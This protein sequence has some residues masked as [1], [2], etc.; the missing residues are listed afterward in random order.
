MAFWRP[1][2]SLAGDGSNGASSSE[3]PS[4]HF[5]PLHR[6]PLHAQ[7]AQL[8]VSARRTEILWAVERHAATV[9]V[10]ATGSGKSTQVPQY[11]LEAGWAADGKMVA[12]AQ[13]RRVAAVTL[14]ARVAQERGVA[15]GTEVGYAVRFDE[16]SDARATRLKFLTDGV[17]LREAMRDP[18]LSRYSVVML[19][20]QYPVDIEYLQEP[21]SADG[22]ILVFL[23]GQEE[24]DV[25][26]RA[27]SDRGGARLLPLP[28]YAALPAQLQES[29]FLPTPRHPV[30]RKLAFYNPFT[31]VE[32]LVTAPVSR[33]SAKQRAGR[34]GRV[35]PGKCFRLCTQTHF[36]TQLAKETL[37][38]IQRTSLAT[39][40]LYLLSMGVRDIAHFEFVSPPPPEA[41]MR[42]LEL[43]H[44]LGAV[45]GACRLVEPLGTH[46]AEFP[47]TPTLA[48]ALLSSFRFGCTEQVVSIASV[49]SVGDVFVSA[50]GS[51]ERR[52][53]IVAA[54]GVFAD[55][56]GDHLTYLRIV[57]EFEASG[58]RRDWCDEFMLSHAALVRALELRRH[59]KK[60]V[61]RFRA[62]S[63]VQ[64]EHQVNAAGD[65][66]D[67]DTADS[68]RVSIL[69]C[70]VSGYFANAATLHADGSYRTVRE[71]RVVQLHPTS[72]FCHTGKSP[73][74]VIFHES[75]LTTDEFVRGVAKI[76]P[77]WLVAAAPDFYRAKDVGSALSGSSG[78]LGLPRRR[79]PA[80][81]ASASAESSTSGA[82]AVAPDGRILF[83]KPAART[84][85]TSTLPVHIGK[86]KGG[87]R[88]QF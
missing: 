14:A 66:A 12:C 61:E 39:V 29:V 44:A 53:R 41:L 58:R 35:R 51:R 3:Q 16:R 76:D 8:P 75:V 22:D 63:S 2:T 37:P 69:K 34:A 46:M 80:T 72:V 11:L 33:A 24:I 59:L 48:K 9:L 49:L 19:G 10:G 50:R 68:E 43:L 42:A 31:G 56:D 74:W 5:N 62:L 65:D 15:L 77:R 67:A 36:R 40:A 73:D 20:R 86:S 64:D 32:S 83:R 57:D 88:S 13:P 1:G 47:V 28:F 52:E 30:R 38:Q 17:L 78:S 21:E 54:M 79:S 85:A 60:Y 81:A 55:P 71:K 27:L 82:P 25:V 6:L 87:L 4:V 7:R 26:V 23:P 18:L 45:D 84:K 70:F